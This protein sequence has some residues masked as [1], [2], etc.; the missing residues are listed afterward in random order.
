[1]ENTTYNNN[2]KQMAQSLS[3]EELIERIKLCQNVIDKLEGDPI[4]KIVISDA[5]TWVSRLD[6]LWQETYDEKQLNG[7]RVLKLA[8]KH[9][10]QLPIKYK[11]DL[12]AAQNALDAKRNTDSSIQRDYDN[13]T[14]LEDQES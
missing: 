11:E 6:G 3:Q 13:E 14:I 9:I 4:W 8:Y 2:I 12:R 5:K 7:L 10:E 1:M